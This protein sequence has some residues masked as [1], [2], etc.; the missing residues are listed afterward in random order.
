MLWF[1]GEFHPMWSIDPVGSVAYPLWFSR[2]HIWSY[3][4]GCIEDG[5]PEER[6][7]DCSSRPGA[8]ST[9]LWNPCSPTLM[10]LPLAFS[11]QRM[12]LILLLSSFHKTIRPGLSSSSSLFHSQCSAFFSLL[13]LNFLCLLDPGN[14]LSCLTG[15][16]PNFLMQ[17]M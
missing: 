4:P 6:W 14:Y 10:P 12:E 3:W 9:M 13:R 17:I 15:T 7:R 8:E 11:V 5:L 1:A 16:L 2:S